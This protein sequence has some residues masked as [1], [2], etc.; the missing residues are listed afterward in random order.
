MFEPVLASHLSITATV[1]VPKC[2][3]YNYREVSLY[4]DY[5]YSPHLY[6]QLPVLLDI[7]VGSLLFLSLLQLHRM[8]D[9]H[10]ELLTVQGG[11]KVNV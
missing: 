4:T 6:E 3:H 2:H 10:S 7:F 1:G 11:G 8:V 9:V 5:N